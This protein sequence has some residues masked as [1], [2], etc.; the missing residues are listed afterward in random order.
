LR[1]LTT[2]RPTRP[3]ERCW[4]KPPKLPLRRTSKC[5]FCIDLVLPGCFSAIDL[6]SLNQAVQNVEPLRAPLSWQT[7]SGAQM[8]KPASAR[9]PCGCRGAER[10]GGHAQRA[11]SSDWPELFER[12]AQRARSEFEGPT[13][14]RAPEGSRAESRTTRLAPE[15]MPA[16]P[17]PALPRQSA[18]PTNEQIRPKPPAASRHTA[19]APRHCAPRSSPECAPG[20]STPCS[21]TNSGPRQS[22]PPTAPAP[23]T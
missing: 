21:A 15:P 18:Q 17:C 9:A 4:S 13:L 22:A 10:Q 3:H 16:Q 19:P 12:S 2:N 1:S 7:P 14:P 11:S 20:K 5:L 8:A 6:G 23:A